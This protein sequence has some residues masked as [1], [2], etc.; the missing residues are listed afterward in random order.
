LH[1]AGDEGAVEGHFDLELLR[2]DFVRLALLGGLF[3]LLGRRLAGGVFA[4]RFLRLLAGPFLLV[5]GG[6]LFPFAFVGRVG[7]LLRRL[8]FSGGFFRFLLFGLLV[9]IAGIFL[10]ALVLIALLILAFTLILVLALTLV[11]VL[12][13]QESDVRAGNW[14]VGW[15]A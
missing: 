6:L 7:F 13:W 4:S 9:L 10:A 12:A 5:F 14:P 8:L 3:G 1:L 2:R 15:G 11:L